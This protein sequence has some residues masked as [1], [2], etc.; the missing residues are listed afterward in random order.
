[1][2]IPSKKWLD[3]HNLRIVFDKGERFHLEHKPDAPLTVGGKRPP[4]VPKPIEE[5]KL[6]IHSAVKQAERD[7][8]PSKEKL[9]LMSTS[10]PDYY[11]ESLLYEISE[12]HKSVIE[13]F[14]D[15]KKHMTVIEKL[16]ATNKKVKRRK[17]TS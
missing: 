7:A 11:A 15:L 4:Y 12:V 17:T 13:C 1:M 8:R 16:M 9:A 6:D 10:D 3:D 5:A 2:P 14:E